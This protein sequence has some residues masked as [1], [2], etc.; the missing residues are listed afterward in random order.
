MQVQ[1][2]VQPFDLAA[3]ESELQYNFSTEQLA[4]YA[5]QSALVADQ[6]VLIDSGQ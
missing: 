2:E 4:E 5:G 3:L 1:G 6:V